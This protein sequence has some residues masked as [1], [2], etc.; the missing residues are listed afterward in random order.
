MGASKPGG[1]IEAP[2]PRISSPVSGP[3][4]LS[5]TSSRFAETVG[6]GSPVVLPVRKTLAILKIHFGLVLIPDGAC[7]SYSA[8]D[9]LPIASTTFWSFCCHQALGPAVRFPLSA[10]SVATSAVTSGICSVLDTINDDSRGEMD[11][12]AGAVPVLIASTTTRPC[13]YRLQQCK[14]TV[15][16]RVSRLCLFKGG[17]WGVV[18]TPRPGVTTTGHVYDDL[19]HRTQGL[20][21][22]I[23]PLIRDMRPNTN[24]EGEKRWREEMTK[25][26]LE[27]TKEESAYQRQPG[28][29]AWENQPWRALTRRMVPLILTSSTPMSTSTSL[30]YS[31]GLLHL[32][33]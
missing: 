13:L 11:A 31:N 17:G 15:Y 27:G 6:C 4:I 30:P 29:L 21:Y 16:K 33:Q 22:D 24:R 9:I 12:M 7:P 5:T 19:G 8:K 10:F 25:R 14:C 28:S 26:E 20:V 32:C 1:V 18:G 2:A 23:G 3:A